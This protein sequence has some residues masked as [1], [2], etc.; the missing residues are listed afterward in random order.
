MSSKDNFSCICSYLA[1]FLGSIRI[2]LIHGDGSAGSELQKWRTRWVFFFFFFFS[3]TPTSSLK[4][5]VD[6]SIGSAFL[7][8]PIT[9]K[10]APTPPRALS[11][12]IVCLF[13]PMDT[14][15]E[16]YVVPQKQRM[17][18]AFSSVSQALFG[19]LSWSFNNHG[20]GNC[21]YRLTMSLKRKRT[22]W[23]HIVIFKSPTVWLDK[24]YQLNYNV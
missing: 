18:S 24:I 20:N 4:S 22:C 23:P 11:C 2:I 3:I 14:V 15:A 5:D 21:Q 6:H 7:P 19:L 12:K 13:L 9:E 8:I 1:S 17:C 10:F 16:F